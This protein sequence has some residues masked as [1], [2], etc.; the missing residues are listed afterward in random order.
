MTCF[1]K[2]RKFPIEIFSL[3]SMAYSAEGGNGTLKGFCPLSIRNMKNFE[4]GPIWIFEEYYSEDFQKNFFFE[5]PRTFLVARYIPFLP[6]NLIYAH[7]AG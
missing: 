4:M 3:N 5:I 2:F 6:F 1:R 7:F